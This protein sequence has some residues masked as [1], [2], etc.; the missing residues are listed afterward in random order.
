MDSWIHDIRTAA[1]SLRR[2]P[3][4]SMLVIVMMAL[5]IGVNAMIYTVVQGI[6]FHQQ[7]FP[8]PARIVTIDSW[9]GRQDDLDELSPPDFLDLKDRTRTLSAFAVYNESMLYLTIGQDPQRFQSAWASAELLDVLQVQPILGRWFSE[10]ECT[11]GRQYE[12]VVLGHRLWTERFG[13][14][15]QILGRT[16]RM[17]G[18]TRTVIGVLPEGLRF[19]EVAELYIPIVVDP[20]EEE[21]GS[22]Y[23]ESVARLAPGVSIEQAQAEFRTLGAQLEQEHPVKGKGKGFRPT[24]LSEALVRDIRPMMLMLALAVLFVLLIACANIA[25]L[26]LA[27]AT[28]RLR[29]L[30]VRMALGAGRG[31]VIRQLLL[32]SVLLGIVGG[33]GGFF[34][35]QWGLELTTRA[36]PIELP[37]WMTFEVDGRVF[38]T[39]LL[40]S[41]VAGMAAGLVPALQLGGSDLITP[42]REG[43]S[44]GGDSPTRRRIRNGL[45]ISEIAIA[46]LM[47]VGSGLMV[48]TFLNLAEQRRG[49]QPKGVLTGQVTLPVAVYPADWQKSAFFQEFRDAIAELPG[50]T[51]AGGVS[52]LHLG[53]SSTAR[54][55]QRKGIDSDDATSPPVSQTNIIT[56]GY[57]ESVGIPLLR[58]RSFT[59]DDDSGSMR[60]VLVNRFAAEMLWPGQEPIGKRIRYGSRDSLWKT[61]VGVIGD[62]RQHVSRSETLAE[63]LAPHAQPPVQTMTWTIRTEGDMGTLSGAVRSLLR[64]RDADLPFYEAR[65]LEEHLRR[66]LWEERLYA[67]LFGAFSALALVIAAVGIYGVMAYAVA[68]RT[69]EIG[70]RMALG[71]AR[72]EVQRMVVFQAMRLSAIGLGLGLAAAFVLTRF[73]VGMLFGIRPDDPPTYIVV[74]SILAM[75]ALLA[76]WVPAARATRVD[77]MIALRHE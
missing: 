69:R 38:A 76:A 29:E 77:P 49:L 56:P 61:V 5:G 27:R 31:R 25:N 64:S 44:G 22:H 13:G 32:E 3:G 67:W 48:R 65:S 37:Y 14:D 34:V 36:I 73:M 7:P 2:A 43:S 28:N 45:V 68:Q 10:E 53:R 17:S 19:P 70:I 6:L 39:T 8:E 47:L 21:R 15:P 50:V 46:V 18:R 9:Q 62:V 12:S 11:E 20:N 4:F 35:A 26:T 16:L 66:A 72:G 55:I 59:A 60:V 75:S 40:L 24:I 30:G 23:L 52:A 51:A 57:L 71:A 42:L 41:I 33:L 54:T 1:R 58:G 63:V 74:V